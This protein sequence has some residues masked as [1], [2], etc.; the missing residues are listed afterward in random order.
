M[1]PTAQLQAQQLGAAIFVVFMVL[2]VGLDVT[3]DHL[4]GVLRRP[5]R[6][7]GALV[8]NYV[9]VPALVFL[10]VQALELPSAYAIGILLVAAAPGGPVGAVLVQKAGGDVPFAV[11]LMALC[12]V[13]NTALTPALAVLMGVVGSDSDVPVGGMVQSIVLFQLL[14]LAL[15]VGWRNRHERSALV[16]RRWFDQGTKIV[17]GLA[18]VIGV[19][20][21]ARR[22]TE[23]PL[24]LA[25]A[26]VS[27]PTI[28]LIAGGLLSTGD[29]LARGTVAVVTGFRSMSVVL[30]L[31]TAWFPTMETVLAALVCSA[32]ML[33]VTATGA[34]IVRKLSR[35]GP[36]DAGSG[37]AAR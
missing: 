18:I 16:A 5:F 6:L 31:V 15:A 36:G 23:V 3:V 14:P 26:A 35:A 20:M 29:A 10:T 28:G 1:D 24:T 34:G 12:N 37:P 9:V 11:S 25:L 19:A 21:E 8:V 4:R 27:V 22:I 32:V 7:L 2:A 17:L 30:L 13:L 33:P